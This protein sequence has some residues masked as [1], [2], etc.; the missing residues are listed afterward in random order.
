MPITVEM[1]KL[2]KILEVFPDGKWDKEMYLL[3]KHCYYKG[4][5]SDS[6]ISILYNLDQV[7]K[8]IIFDYLSLCYG[9]KDYKYQCKD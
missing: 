1:Q 3:L 6:Q 8:T 9:Q 7:R 2:I 5:L 4:F